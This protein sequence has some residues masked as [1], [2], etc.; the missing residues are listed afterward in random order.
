MGVTRS[1]SVETA[2]VPS[3]H[4]ANYPSSSTAAWEPRSTIAAVTVSEAEAVEERGESAP[5]NV[6]S[7]IP[8][9]ETA[10]NQGQTNERNSLTRRKNI[11]GKQGRSMHPMWTVLFKSFCALGQ[12]WH[13]LLLVARMPRKLLH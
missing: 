6:S 4:E 8:R 3:D 10:T 5:L 7:F 1:A 12:T 2:A 13:C 11:K 9:S